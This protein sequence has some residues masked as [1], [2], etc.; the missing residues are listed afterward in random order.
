MKSLMTGVELAAYFGVTKGCV[1]QWDR[2][3]IIRRID[4]KYDPEECE[5]R[6]AQIEDPTYPI[7][8]KKSTQ[9]KVTSQGSKPPMTFGE[10]KTE[11]EIYL[12]KQA[13]RE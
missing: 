6:L 2:E 5:R 12:A 7:K 3:G 11:K 10:A 1:S 9:T 8:R 13:K 4:R